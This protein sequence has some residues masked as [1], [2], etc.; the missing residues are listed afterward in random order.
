MRWPLIEWVKIL[1]RKRLGLALLISTLLHVIFVTVS[2]S[3]AGGHHS[4]ASSDTPSMTL[5][6]R[7]ISGDTSGALPPKHSGS[8]TQ[9]KLA[10][11]N[12]EQRLSRRARPLVTVDL[13]VPESS[14]LSQSGRLVLKLW[15]SHLGTVE[16]VVID[17]SSLPEGFA[18]AVASV[19]AKARFAP[20]EVDG[21]PVDSVLLIE[22]TH[23]ADPVP[24]PASQ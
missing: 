8:L 19:F 24:P 13:D 11:S 23:E 15:I 20:G 1:G 2:Y 17:K 4:I 5:S 6:A 12:P 21:R 14:L 22:V 3:S 10:K 18:K 9:D 7:I 16:K